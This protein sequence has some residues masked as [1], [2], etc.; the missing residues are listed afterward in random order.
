MQALK[1]SLLK[2]D[3]TY[4]WED[5][6]QISFLMVG[7]V[8]NFLEKT[9]LM[10]CYL[11]GLLVRLYSQ[12]VHKLFRVLYRLLGGQPWLTLPGVLCLAFDMKP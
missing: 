7:V 3:V 10:I 5:W 11:A 2:I 4:D 8:W 12:V 1:K 6:Y 9:R